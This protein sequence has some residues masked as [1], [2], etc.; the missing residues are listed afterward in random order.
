MIMEVRFFTKTVK[1]KLINFEDIT[2][3][4]VG[5]LSIFFVMYFPIFGF[6]FFFCYCVFC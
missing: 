6:Y 1:C 2:I 5:R 4:I 3:I